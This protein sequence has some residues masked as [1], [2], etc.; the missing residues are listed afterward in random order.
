MG[1]VIFNI[2]VL[3]AL[4]GASLGIGIVKVVKM[5]ACINFEI[6][7]ENICFFCNFIDTNVFRVFDFG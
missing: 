7:R 5:A 6:F 1:Y 4:D 3:K 2:I